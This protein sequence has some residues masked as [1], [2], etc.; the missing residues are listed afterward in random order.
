MTTFF[1]N[2]VMILE[3]SKPKEWTKTS[4]VLL[5]IPIEAQQEFLRG[6]ATFSYRPADSRSQWTI[7]NYGIPYTTPDGEEWLLAG[8]LYRNFQSEGLEDWLRGLYGLEFR[9]EYQQCVVIS[10]DLTRKK[11]V[12]VRFLKRSELWPSDDDLKAYIDSHR[13]DSVYPLNSRA[14]QNLCQLMFDQKSNYNSAYLL[15]ALSEQP[16]TVAAEALSAVGFDSSLANKHLSSINPNRMQDALRHFREAQKVAAG[17]G[18]ED[19]EPEHVLLALIRDP[20]A[21]GYQLL[22]TLNIDRQRLEHE[23][24][25]RVSN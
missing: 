24:V 19:T 5:D 3:D 10:I 15:I 18:S 9:G 7:Q 20:D 22:S 6:G 11:P 21:C 16:N 2:L 14:V 17:Y 23:I 4:R 8:Q 25:Q 1:K 13:R 12:N